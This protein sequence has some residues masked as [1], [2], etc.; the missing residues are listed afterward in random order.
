M[1]KLELQSICD[2]GETDACIGNRKTVKTRSG[3]SDS[4]S[5]SKFP[6]TN[7]EKL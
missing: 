7:N 5:V 2:A 6:Q 4:I 3:G 1:N